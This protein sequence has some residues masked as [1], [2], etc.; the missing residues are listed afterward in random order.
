M[1]IESIAEME[2]EELDKIGPKGLSAYEVY[3]KNGGILSETEWLKS[4]RGEQGP[5]G[6]PGAVKMQVV[7]TLP[8]VGET[9]TI[10]LLKKDKPGEQNL[11]DEYVYTKTTG[12]EHIGDTSV[13]LADYYTKDESDNRIEGFYTVE[14]DKYTETSVSDATK[15]RLQ[16]II[17]N[18]Y[19][20]GVRTIGLLVYT[21]LSCRS[22]L[23]NL[24]ESM[25]ST[26]TTSYKFMGFSIVDAVNYAFV[27][28]SLTVKGTWSNNVFTLSSV[29]NYWGNKWVYIGNKSDYLS[30]TNTTTYNPTRDYHPATKKYVD[31]NKVTKAGVLEYLEEENVYILTLDAEVNSEAGNISNMVNGTTDTEIC[32]YFTE[33]I[34]KVSPKKSGTLILN[35]INTGYSRDQLNNNVFRW[36]FSSHK[37]YTIGIDTFGCRI[38]YLDMTFTNNT[39]GTYNVT[40]IKLAY[41]PIKSQYTPTDNNHVVNKKYVDDLPKSYT[42]YD[43][44]KTQVLKNVN[45]TLTWVDE[46]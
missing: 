3:V 5:Q 39:D 1:E 17:N 15:E 10:Y 37:F 38:N 2:I 20:K 16:W 13:D 40:R 29:D 23:L 24:A 28:L 42:G 4:L 19:Q 33:I 44:T 36:D 31:D 41:D 21:K 30:K 45:G 8:D 35:I 34:N 12:W 9:D 43:A 25:T 11:Y 14:I 26:G 27:S 6:Q 32:G 7:D 18:A 22:V 46:E